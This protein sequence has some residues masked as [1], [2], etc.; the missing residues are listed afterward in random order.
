LSGV[1][2]PAMDLWIENKNEFIE[3]LRKLTHITQELD[4]GFLIINDKYLLCVFLIIK[5]LIGA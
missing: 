5:L 1:K 3:V 2:I 4:N